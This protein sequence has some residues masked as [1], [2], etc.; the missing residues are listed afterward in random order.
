MF[1]LSIFFVRISGAHLSTVLWGAKQI[2]CDDATLEV[3]VVMPGGIAAMDDRV[4]A[5]HS[6]YAMRW[7]ELQQKSAH[8]AN[9]KRFCSAAGINEDSMS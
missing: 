5:Q 9:V 1:D 4:L 3:C 2:G 8:N 6:T 7:N